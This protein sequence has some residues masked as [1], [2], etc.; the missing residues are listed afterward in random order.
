MPNK[1]PIL[2]ALAIGLIVG[3]GAS[4]LAIRPQ[5]DGT[6]Q[7]ATSEG[8]LSPER[9]VLY[10]YDPMVP[11]QHFDKPGK[12]PFMDMDL[13][14][15][16]ADDEE[17]GAVSID[18]RTVQSLGVRT[19]AAEQGTLWK[20]IDTVGSVMADEN[21]VEAVQART[22]G[23]VERLHVRAMNDPVKKG[24]LLA[25][26]YSPDLLAAQEEYRIALKQKDDADWQSAALQ[27][28]TLLGISD[29]QIKKLEAGGEPARRVA[30]Y[31]PTSG[32]VAELNVQ[33]GSSVSAGMPMFRIADFSRIWVIAEVVEDQAGWIAPGKWADVTV[34]ALPG[35]TF[36]GK[37]DYLYP[38]FNRGARTLKA[39][40]VLGNPELALKPGM[41]A[42]V[43]LYG[44]KAD[45]AVLV[46]TEAVIQTGR[47]SIVIVREGE[48][49]F[50]PIAVKTG[51][52]NDGRTQILAG[53]SGGEQVVV[54]G[55]FLIESEANLRGALERLRGPEQTFLGTGEITHVDAAKNE[56]EMAHDPIPAIEWPAMTMGFEVKDPALLK[57][58][59]KGQKVEF[60][61]AKEGEGYVVVGIRP[62]GE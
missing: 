1:I 23:F 54:S 51:I 50:R 24:Q 13:V 8:A 34:P 41:F 7:P 26:V 12:S 2:I 38:E 36:E 35:K 39:R 62:R 28:L 44:G 59:Q 43:T 32:V 21:R 57:G 60:D 18:P 29:A 37:V 11:D 56:L 9:E 49:K 4:W 30:Y 5:G 27:R 46:P 53:L 17:A 6:P 31:A 52:E 20:R 48:G 55:Q 15:K 22:T 40:I 42:N 16:Y 45:E 61:L 25:E 33:E 14:P 3:G 19:A 10:W 47:R 58:L